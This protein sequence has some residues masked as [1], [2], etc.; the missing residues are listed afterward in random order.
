MLPRSLI[1]KEVATLKYEH[2][3]IKTF[4]VEDLIAYE[5]CYKVG[6]RNLSRLPLIYNA[7]YI[8][9]YL[10]ELGKVYYNLY[11]SQGENSTYSVKLGSGQAGNRVAAGRY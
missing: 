7:S 3:S 4:N 6:N 8:I 10:T 9:T 1:D 2:D 5:R 11:Y